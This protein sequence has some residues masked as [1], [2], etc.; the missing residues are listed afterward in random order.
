MNLPPNSVKKNTRMPIRIIVAVVAFLWTAVLLFF[1][2]F[3]IKNTYNYVDETARIQARAAIEKNLAHSS[4]VARLGGIYALRISGSG[5]DSLDGEGQALFTTDGSTLIKINPFYM[6]KLVHAAGAASSGV[7]GRVLSKNAAYYGGDGDAWEKSALEQLQGKEINEISEQS[8]INGTEYMRLIRPLIVDEAFLSLPGFENYKPGDVWGGASVSVPMEPLMKTANHTLQMLSFSYGFLWIL[9]LAVLLMSALKI[10][11]HER[12]RDTAEIDL[13]NLKLGLE[14]RVEQGVA[15]VEKRRQALQT[16]MDYTEA[17]VYLKDL[18]YRYTMANK[19]YELMVKPYAELEGKTYEEARPEYQELNDKIRIYEERVVLTHQP[20][21]PEEVFSLDDS[22]RLYAAALFPVL[23]GNSQLDGVGG[24]FFDITQRIHME[25]AL[26]R[27]KEE[28]ESASRAKSH[29][30]ANVSHEIRTPLNGVIGMADLLLRTRLS[31]EQASMAA[32][33][34]SGGD[35]LLIVLNDIL[36]FS[37]IEAGKMCLDPVP[38]SLRDVVFDVAKGFAPVAYKKR[39]ELIV[40]IAPQVPDHLVGDYVRIRQVLLNLLSNAIKFTEEGEVTI[41]IRTLSQEANRVCLRISVTDT[42]IGIPTDKQEHIFSAFEQADSSTT[43]KYGGTGLG[44]AISA[45][46]ADLM[47]SE[48]HLESR[49]GFGSTFWFD[50]ELEFSEGDSPPRPVVSTELLKGVRVLVVDDN[51]TNLLIIAEQLRTWGM[52]VEKAQSVNEAM[53]L[54]SVASNRRC[55]FSLVLTDMQMPGKD[56]MDFVSEMQAK[57]FLRDIP[58]VMLSS[59]DLMNNSMLA[60][61][62]VASLTKPVRPGELMRAIASALGI[63]ERFD[64][65]LIQQ[66]AE[67]GLKH[68]SHISLKVLLVEDMEMNQI[69]ASHMLNNLGHSVVIAENGQ[70]AFNLIEKEKFDLVFM[71][72]QMP[73]MDGVQAA[74]KIREWE[75][76]SPGTRLPIVAMTAHALK[77]DKEKYLECGMDG[78]IAKPVLLNELAEV[79]DGMIARFGLGGELCAREG[80]NAA[81]YDLTCRDEYE[82][83]DDENLPAGEDALDY[84]VIAKSFVG[85]TELTIQSMEIFIRDVPGLIGEIGDAIDRRDNSGLI[86]SAHTLKGIVGYY[87][88]S[89]PFKACQA[90]EALGREQKLPEDL[91]AVTRQESVVLGEMQKLI[92]SMTDYIARQA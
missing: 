28:A 14:K 48:L 40:H 79:L 73:V 43:R 16:F 85:N 52:E 26:V 38:F 88:K 69:V 64:I 90:L 4:W 20:V 81:S 33:I 34:K 63:W 91:V 86:V 87:N 60:T 83:I 12:N 53:S 89:A 36:D 42:G 44:L 22:G 25:K 68:T 30:L 76:E 47:G 24:M 1:L 23:D 75:K 19:N 50:L 32:T 49:P 41:T 82:K 56:G 17:L 15:E 21:H 45:R 8:L 71:D 55:D 66:K 70:H 10:F 9:G 35:S 61:A 18:D 37:K 62:L 92:Q 31:A 78:Y 6:T 51:Q 57:P 72:I 67:E 74:R 7:Q 59:D 84:D 2:W 5:Y 3:N 46:L 11:K 29:F 13:L 54:L 39:L 27:A 58:V 80:R 65:N 77:G